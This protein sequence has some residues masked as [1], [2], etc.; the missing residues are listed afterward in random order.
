MPTSIQRKKLDWTIAT[1]ICNQFKSKEFTCANAVAQLMERLKLKGK[2]ILYVNV[3]NKAE[4]LYIAFL[5]NEKVN[6]SASGK[7]WALEVHG[8]I[9]DNLHPYGEKLRV[10]KKNFMY[11][12]ATNE[13]KPTGFT[14]AD[15]RHWS[16]ADFDKYWDE[17]LADLLQDPN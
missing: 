6:A 5:P 17:D 4:P 13:H 8:K 9:F 15:I 1:A 10:W 14:N 11:A 12:D 16:K 2:P 7:H 3:D